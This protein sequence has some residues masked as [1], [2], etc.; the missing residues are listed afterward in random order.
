M[1]QERTVK[2]VTGEIVVPF[3]GVQ[4]ENIGVGIRVNTENILCGIISL[5]RTLRVLR[6]VSQACGSALENAV[7]SRVGAKGID[8]S[9]KLVL[10]GLRLSAGVN[11]KPG[12]VEVLPAGAEVSAEISDAAGESSFLRRDGKGILAL[13][14][15][16]RAQAHVDRVHLSYL[17]FM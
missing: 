12:V 13:G 10:E 6:T 9:V 17:H 16:S 3:D 14:N 2:S 11:V 8:H 5:H 15:G 1:L 4:P 7:I